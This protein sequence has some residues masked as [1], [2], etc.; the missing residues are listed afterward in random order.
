MSDAFAALHIAILT[1][2]DTRTEA[3]DKSGRVLVDRL[4]AAGH[5]LHEKAICA[6]DVHEIRARV[7]RWIADDRP[8]VVI[9]TGG[10]GLTGR[11]VTPQAVEVLFDR[12]IDGF[13]EMF[14]MLSYESIGTSTL[15]SRALAGVSKA[16]F[17]F[18]L[19]GSSGACADGWD[20]LIAAQI[21]ARTRPCNLHELLP[22][23]TER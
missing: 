12:R 3:D 8:D 2:S 10:T 11:D 18:C 16:T 6:D 17:V 1:V 5:V 15:Q 19:P 14:R 9:T 21:D 7:A 20:K 22:R 13:G 4:E 23:L